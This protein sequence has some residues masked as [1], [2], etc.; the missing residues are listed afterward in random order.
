MDKELIKWL[1]DVFSVVPDTTIR[2]MFG[3]VGVFR[4]RLMFA[5]AFSD[6]RIAFKADGETTADFIAEACEEWRYERKDGKITKMGY[7]YIP[8]RIVDDPDELLEWAA[9]AF[10]VAMRADRKKPPSQ[11]KHKNA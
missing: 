3:G 5:L 4:D 8:E 7:W 11:R 10:D 1:E 9:K 2:K 6:G